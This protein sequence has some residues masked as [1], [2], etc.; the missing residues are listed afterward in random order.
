MSHNPAQTEMDRLRHMRDAANAALRFVTGRT[1][2]DLESD[3]M[4]Q[5]ALIRAL[6]VIGE[7]A[8]KLSVSIQTS[9]PSVPWGEII[10]MR[11]RLIH[12]Y[13]DVDLDIVW[14]VAT[15]KLASLVEWLDSVLDQPHDT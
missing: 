12:G 9:Y 3:Q 10:G 1:R 5:F 15:V 4:L 14:N 6:E 8:D 13:F 2:G 11:H 7:A